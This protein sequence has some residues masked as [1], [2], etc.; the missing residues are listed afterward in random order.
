MSCASF[1]AELG[2]GVRSDLTRASRERSPAPRSATTSPGTRCPTSGACFLNP[3]LRAIRCSRNPWTAKPK[4]FDKYPESGMKEVLLSGSSDKEYSYDA[5]IGGTFHGAMTYHAIKR[6][7]GR[8]LP[9]HLRRP[10]HPAPADAGRGGLPAAPPA[11]GQGREQGAPDLHLA[12]STGDAI[13]GVRRS[14][15]PAAS[16]PPGD[17]ALAPGARQDLGQRTASAPRA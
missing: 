1:F 2:D 15:E 11:R 10:A 8:G 6:D 7:R 9:A 5:S 3:A 14:G 16:L 13:Q 4:R 12:D 17:G